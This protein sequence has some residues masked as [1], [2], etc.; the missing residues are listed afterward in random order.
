MV[1]QDSQSDIHI[2]NRAQ[3]AFVDAFLELLHTKDFDNIHTTDIISG[4][5][6]SRG[7]FYYYYSDKYAFAQWLFDREVDMLFQYISAFIVQHSLSEG[8][9]YIQSSIEFYRHIYQNR[10]FFEAMQDKRFSMFSEEKFCFAIRDRLLENTRV[11]IPMWQEDF[12]ME[13][14]SF[15]RCF[16]II[17]IIR[18]WR[19]CDY[20]YSAEYIAQQSLYFTNN[21]TFSSISMVR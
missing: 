11:E 5:G 17:D 14:Y 21:R 15:L 1:R 12:D 20:R 19:C 8:Q 6:Y 7:S 2:L 4:S 10:L 13:F 3:Q 16:E 9:T 18:Y